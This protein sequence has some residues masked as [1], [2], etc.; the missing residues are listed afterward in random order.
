MSG[1]PRAKDAPDESE[2]TVPRDDVDDVIGIAAELDKQDDEKLSIAELKEVA[3]Q[4][5]QDP[6]YVEK[7]VEVLEVRRATEKREA[8]VERERVTLLKR[9]AF[10]GGIAA[11]ALFIVVGLVIQGGL[12]SDLAEVERQQA[13]VKNVLE[14]QAATERRLRDAPRDR[15]RDAELAGSENRVRIERAR[16]DEAAAAYNE[17]AGGPLSSLYARIF[18]LPT[19]VPMSN[20]VTEW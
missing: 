9:R 16:Y 20:E 19:R 10:I 14:R 1:P 11:L 7:A 17:S 2:P 15:D 8:A 18:G 4:V 6:T 3:T 12:R 13:Q 5:D